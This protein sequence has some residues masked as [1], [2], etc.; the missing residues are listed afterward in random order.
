M[1]IPVKKIHS[2]FINGFGEE[3]RRRGREREDTHR[4]F[5]CTHVCGHPPPHHDAFLLK[6]LNAFFRLS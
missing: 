4:V 5:G 6:E 2:L 3:K 1:D